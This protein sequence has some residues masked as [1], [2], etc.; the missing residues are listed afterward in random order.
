MLGTTQAPDKHCM[1]V[2]G[3]FYR[4]L[5]QN[6]HL[7]G[8][9]SKGP[10]ILDVLMSIPDGICL[11]HTATSDQISVWN[12]KTEEQIKTLTQIG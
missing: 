11:Y 5:S 12:F 3:M 6:H 10:F 7:L 1:M 4:P 9:T 8:G 2:G